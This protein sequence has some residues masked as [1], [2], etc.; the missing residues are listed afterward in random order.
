M[1]GLLSADNHLKKYIAY[2]DHITTKN[3]KTGMDQ[4]VTPITN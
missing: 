2:A 1:E 3:K 4:S